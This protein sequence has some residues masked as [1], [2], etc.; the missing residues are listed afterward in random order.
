MRRALFILP[1]RIGDVLWA[2]PT[3]RALSRDYELD[4]VCAS[5]YMLK[6]MDWLRSTG[7]AVKRF[8]PLSAPPVEP[9]AVF[10]FDWGQR[11]WPTI[12]P[13]YDRYANGTLTEMPFR[14]LADQIAM[15]AGVDIAGCEF[16]FSTSPLPPAEKAKDCILLHF[17]GAAFPKQV[18]GLG[19][20][21]FPGRVL[22]ICSGDEPVH[23]NYP[24]L[25]TEGD[26]FRLVSL[27]ASS[28][29]V[30]GVS[31]CVVL[32]AAILGKPSLCIHSITDKRC[33][34]SRVGPHA[35]DIYQQRMTKSL[36]EAILESHACSIA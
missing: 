6:L 32:L 35:E 17:S 23:P 26:F 8:I 14:H 34:I 31:S 22:S 29:A 9:T 36:Q 27:I 11:D 7:I 3:I 4:W 1:G 12:M 2:L 20:V 25:A 5:P 33:A 18:A 28:R 10:H 19:E 24:K 16:S 15:N 21:S 13:G 30:V